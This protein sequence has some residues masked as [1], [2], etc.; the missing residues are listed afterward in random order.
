V[1]SVYWPT[2]LSTPNATRPPAIAAI[3]RLSDLD[4]LIESASSENPILIRTGSINGPET[5]GWSLPESDFFTISSTETTDALTQLAATHQRIWHYRLYD[6]VSD[7]DGLIRQWL[8]D[9]TIQEFSQP[10]PGRDYLLLEGYRTQAAIPAPSSNTHI[11]FPDASLTLVGQSYP[12]TIPAG[13]TLYV[14]L[15]WQSIVG[16]APPATPALSLRLYDAQGNFDLQNDTLVVTN[17][18]GQNVQSLALPI[19]A[20][21]IPG[22]YTLSLVLYAPDTLAPY[23]AIAGDDSPLPSP[24]L[25][26]PVAIDL[27]TTMPHTS[28]PLA[29]FDYIDLLHVELPTTPLAPGTS[30]T[31]AWTWRPQP[32][33]Y[34]DNYTAHLELIGGQ[35]Q[36]TTRLD[37]VLGNENYS[38]SRWPEQFP[39]TQRVNI[40]LPVDLSPG[41]YRAQLSLTR[42]SDGQAIPAHQP[43][44]P[45]Q[46]PSIDI[47][48]L[49]I[50]SPD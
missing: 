25:L 13:E 20:D 14:A 21:T 10:I 15:T 4:T 42:T 32:S 33:A 31:S 36:Q 22:D 46:Q 12:A 41:T 24:L 48:A 8:N 34:R 26:G 43:W 37:F 45:W 11:E 7:P 44:R 39:L 2:E 1:I 49:E 5:L 18:A 27:P 40:S 50:I 29:T 47:G 30:F 38:S 16:N 3:T 17:A 6:T 9:H 35:P 23:A 28:Q 19:P